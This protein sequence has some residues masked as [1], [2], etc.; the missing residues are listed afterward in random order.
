MYSS[1][2][3]LSLAEPSLS[4]QRFAKLVEFIGIDCEYLYLPNN[5]VDID[6]L[7]NDI[8]ADTGCLAL[9]C[10]TLAAMNNNQGFVD[11]FKTFLYS[12]IPNLFI[13]NISPD[14]VKIDA[15]KDF[16]NGAIH[17]VSSFPSNNCQYHVS[18]DFREISR[19]FTGLSFGP[20]NNDFDYG[21]QISKPTDKID[22][23]ISINEYPLF[24]KIQNGSCNIFALAIGQFLDL[25]ENAIRPSKVKEYF[26]RIV[27]VTMFLKYVFKDNCWHNDNAQACLIIDDPLLVKKYG[28]VDYEMLFE[29]MRNH[30]FSITIAFI[31]WNYRRTKKEAMNLFETRENTFSLCVH[32]NNHTKEE[33]GITD[34][35]FID[36]EVKQAKYRI[37]LYSHHSLL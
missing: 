2:T 22:S 4:D 30:D 19:H 21:L 24:L 27:P 23:L 33:F 37:L 31:P 3:I 36:H 11:S 6:S 8:K 1:V 25:D 17:S 12:K 5:V 28:F 32:G 20:I 16:T 34:C 9:D 14:Q 10:N 26:S 13:Y 15:L 35:K 7:I 29:A 18:D